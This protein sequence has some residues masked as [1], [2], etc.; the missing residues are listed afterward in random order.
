MTGT[1]LNEWRDTFYFSLLIQ[2]RPL[3]AV[4]KSRPHSI[5]FIMNVW[6]RSLKSNCRKHSTDAPQLPSPRLVAGAPSWLVKYRSPEYLRTLLL[7]T[8]KYKPCFY[9]VSVLTGD[10]LSGFKPTSQ[11]GCFR[12]TVHPRCSPLVPS[13]CLI[14]IVLNK[15]Y[16]L[17]MSLRATCDGLHLK[18]WC[19]IVI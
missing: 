5:M 13:C 10:I 2:T 6:I 9:T 11:T 15:H 12:L 16:F 3:S 7:R 17:Y 1:K 14:S 8:Q 4:E 18:Y 19:N